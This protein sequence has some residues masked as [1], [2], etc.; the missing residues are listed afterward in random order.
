MKLTGTENVV[1]SRHA[2]D[3]LEQYGPRHIR[4]GL[5]GL[6]FRRSRYLRHEE[7][8]QLGYRP[9]FEARRSQGVRSW[10]FRLPLLSHELIAVLTQG[11]RPGEMVWTTTYAPDPLTLRRR[12]TTPRTQAA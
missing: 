9:G 2:L 5:A 3:R 8:V 1:V 11:A 10:Y 7:I 4:E 6:L 12:G